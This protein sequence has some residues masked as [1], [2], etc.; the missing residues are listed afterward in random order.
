M[1]I[2][3]INQS[4]P[5]SEDETVLRT[6]YR[7]LLDS[8]AAG[9]AQTYADHFTDDADYIIAN[10]VLE[11]G[12][13]EIAAGH[14]AIFNTWA[15][16]TRLVGCIQRLRFL[17]PDTAYIIATGAIVMPGQSEADWSEATIYSL[18]AR[19]AAGGWR[20]IAYQNTPIQS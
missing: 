15:K 12:R 4:P 10:G 17:T 9:D 8:W 5:T 14:Q 19:K 20:F 11:H 1:N 18:V 13:G 3:A 7:T 2:N 6:L 16:N